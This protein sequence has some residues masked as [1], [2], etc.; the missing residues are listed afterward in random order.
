MY[1]TNFI[2]DLSNIKYIFEFNYNMNFS[3]KLNEA[4]F[5]FKL[6]EIEKIEI[7]G[8]LRTEEFIKFKRYFDNFNNEKWERKI[9]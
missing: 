6:D 7:S 2:N 8:T 4:N 3:I 9:Y 1:L 5:S